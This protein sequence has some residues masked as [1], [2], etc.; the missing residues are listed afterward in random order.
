MQR[1]LMK[2]VKFRYLEAVEKA[3]KAMKEHSVKLD[4]C[5]DGDMKVRKLP[6]F[7]CLPHPWPNLACHTPLV[8]RRV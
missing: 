6:L 2:A 4:F 1:A 7:Y 8:V 5:Q 3:G